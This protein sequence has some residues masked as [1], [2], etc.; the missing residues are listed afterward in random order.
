MPYEITIK[1]TTTKTVT[2]R[3]EWTVVDKRPWKATEVTEEVD[4][5]YIYR[6]TDQFLEK[7]PLKE[8]LGYAP[9]VQAEQTESTEILKQTV[10]ELD[11]PAVIKA[12]NKI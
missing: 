8:I 10:D 7:N 2:K 3:G 12:I 6:S 1:R 11:L 4:K 9:D 5:S